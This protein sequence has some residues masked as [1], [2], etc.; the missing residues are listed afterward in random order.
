MRQREEEARLIALVR[1]QVRAAVL[2]EPSPAPG[3][4]SAPRG[5]FVTIE[6]GGQVIGCRGTLAP[7]RKTLE[8]ELL[9]AARS[10]ALHDPRYGPRRPADLA[11]FL[12]TITLVERLEPLREIAALTPEAGLVLTSGGRV[13][14]VL[15][16]EG[17]DAR[18][19][20]RWAYQKAGVSFGASATLQRLIATRFRG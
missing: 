10:A 11:D 18:T 5:V 19:R 16:F 9:E 1:A 20:L 8:E 15:P 2:R 3:G 7:R 17:R 12:V 14:V 4:A 13:G 6:R